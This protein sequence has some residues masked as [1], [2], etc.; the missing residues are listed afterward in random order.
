[1]GGDGCMFCSLVCNRNRADAHD[2]GCDP[3]GQV[4]PWRALP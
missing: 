1:M 3:V 4:R 2:V